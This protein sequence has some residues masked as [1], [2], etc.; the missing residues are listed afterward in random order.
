MIDRT[1][2][3]EYQDYVQMLMLYKQNK[4]AYAKF[5]SML[6][7]FEFSQNPLERAKF[8][9]EKAAHSRLCKKFY[10]IKKAY[11]EAVSRA[12]LLDKGINLSAYQLAEI[13]AISIPMTMTDIISAERNVKKNAEVKRTLNAAEKEVAR[14]V[15]VRAG[16][17]IPAF[18]LDEPE[19]IADTIDA[20]DISP[21][22]SDDG[23]IQFDPEF[24]KL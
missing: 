24:D 12:E 9:D 6:G 18:L 8:W 20:S 13:A 1:Q 7:H 21:D 19:E 4:S 17:T 2:L 22:I 16:I 10:A 23:K 15:C 3:K 11:Q 5:L 14:Q